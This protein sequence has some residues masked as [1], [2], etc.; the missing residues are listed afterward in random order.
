MKVS[1]KINLQQ[2]ARD[3]AEQKSSG[4]TR[5][6][7]CRINGINVSTFDHRCK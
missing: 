1:H 2:W 5:K 6:E 4:M 3:M 7:W